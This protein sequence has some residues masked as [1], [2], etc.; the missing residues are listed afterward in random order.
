V[1]IR[2]GVATL[3]LTL[4]VSALTFVVP[5]TPSAAAARKMS[6]SQVAEF[7][8]TC[9]KH[10]SGNKVTTYHD[11]ECAANHSSNISLVSGVIGGPSEYPTYSAIGF[12]FNGATKEYTCYA[13]P[14]RIGAAPINVTIDCP[15]WILSKEYAKT[16]FPLVYQLASSFPS[17]SPP[18]TLAEVQSEASSSPGTPSVTSG[19]GRIFSTGITPL[20][21]FQMSYRSGIGRD[22][23]LWFYAQTGAD[24]QLATA[25]LEGPPGM[26]GTCGTRAQA[27]ARG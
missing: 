25:S 2:P 10:N 23:C 15:L 1:S 17:G 20:A 26:Y 24:G 12:L 4:L 6:P 13:F 3:A 7:A 11:I 18:P 14:D 8:L 5:V 27:V 19:S 22:W 16:N 9:A 21:T